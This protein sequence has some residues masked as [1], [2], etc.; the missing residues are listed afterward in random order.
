MKSRVLITMLTMSLLLI[1]CTDSPSTWDHAFGKGASA[2]PPK[3][4]QPPEQPTQPQIPGAPL[5]THCISVTPHTTS[6]VCSTRFPARV[7]GDVDP[8]TPLPEATAGSPSRAARHISSP[9][10]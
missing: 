2:R 5:L 10:S 6:A 9:A 8:H 1:G 3:A 7:M 4:P